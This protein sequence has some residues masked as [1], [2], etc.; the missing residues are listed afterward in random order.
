MVRRILIGLATAVFCAG[1][2][3]PAAYGQKE[4]EKERRA[5]AS[6]PRV[7]AEHSG[8]LAVREGQ[9]LRLTTDIGA[10]RVFTSR[11]LPAGQ[12][13][14][15]VRVEADASQPDA[16]K[17]VEQ[18]T[19]AGRTAPEGALITGN[20][21]WRRFR[22]RILVNYEVRIPRRFNVDVQTQAGSVSVEDLDGQV[23]V[24]SA[25]GNL[26]LGRVGP[27]RLETQ[28]GHIMVR[29]VLGNLQAVTAGGHINVGPVQG[30]AMLRSLGG[31]VSA[32]SVQG[33]ANFE[34][35]GGNISLRRAGGGI[36]ATTA[37]GRI[38]VGE[39][40]GAIRAK[41]AGGGIRVVKL[42]GPTQLETTGGSIYL[43][44]VQGPVRAITGAGGITAWLV[45]GGKLQGLSQLESS[46][47]DIV[48]FIP[49]ELAITIEASV[50][51][52]GDHK[53]DPE[54][55]IPLKVTYATPGPRPRVIRAEATLNGGG[56]VL[57]LKAQAGDIRLKFSDNLQAYYE[58]LYKQQIELFEKSQ[59]IEQMIREYQQRMQD[60]MRREVEQM[61][62]ERLKQEEQVRVQ[63]EQDLKRR[64]KEEGS[65]GTVERW[66][67]ALSER[68][69]GRV[70]TNAD[71]QAG[72]L[73]YQVQPKYPEAAMQRGIEGWVWLEV[74]IDKDGNVEE[75][76]RIDGD[77]ML[78]QSAIEAVKQWRYSPTYL[79]D[80]PVAVA[81]VVRLN[82][83]LK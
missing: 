27:A 25:G 39:A 3:L 75:V 61:S 32:I 20:A 17:L 48:V 44:S 29:E 13:T 77:T 63:L 70:K 31:H 21:P 83:R 60:Q 78:V 16:Q 12:M 80:R 24:F 26:T 15:R 81:T 67:M 30:D 49:R 51:S 64:A 35:M 6:A 57:R 8:A 7:A 11:E 58:R 14:W 62:L 33:T 76:N 46:S 59:Q 37:G 54:D 82:F 52:D 41:T 47:G 65:R 66:K 71:T 9:K 4:K 72:K 56:D 45:S 34:T 55:G 10:V 18:F 68:L 5:E 50:E 1:L 53:I 43:T 22:G 42:V 79:G 23:A 40:T 73:V 19:V 28:G 36:T 38:D 2:L 69:A 74:L